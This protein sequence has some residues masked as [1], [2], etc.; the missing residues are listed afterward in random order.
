MTVAEDFA[1]H[2]RHLRTRAGTPAVRKLASDTGFGKTT[3]SDAFAGRRL[4][5][6]DVVSALAEALDADPG[7]LRDK[8]VGARGRATSAIADVPDWLTA[9]RTNIPDLPGARTIEDVCAIAATDP[10]SALEWCWSVVRTGALRLAHT[11]YDTIPGSW[12]SDNVD[13]YGRAEEDGR[14]P[15]GS[16]AIA[17]QAH[18]YYH[19]AQNPDGAELP[20]R[21]IVLQVVV[22]SYRLAWQAQ[23][24]VVDATARKQ[25]ASPHP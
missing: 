10:K 24:A 22:L 21:A 9:V 7:D 6:W 8:W 19:L 14:M 4:P 2:L 17:N 11:L 1:R 18:L 13:T 23:T 15:A 5:T 16:R 25:N 20:S 12:S 3:I